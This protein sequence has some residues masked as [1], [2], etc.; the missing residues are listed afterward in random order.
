MGCLQATLEEAQSKWDDAVASK[1]RAL[2]QLGASLEAEQRNA[3]QLRKAL[4]EAQH[5]DEAASCRA[6]VLTQQATETQ[7][8]KA[9]AEVR[10]RSG[11]QCLGS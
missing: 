2:Q 8:W 9:R 11:F 6:E 10:P 5:R 1:D 3:Q 4:A 7:H